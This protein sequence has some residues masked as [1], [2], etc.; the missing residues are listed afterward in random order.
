MILQY[1]FV[2]LLL[3]GAIAFALAPI[4]V[5][6]LVAPRKRAGNKADTFECGLLPTDETWVR[7]RVQ[8][9]VYALLFVVFDVETVFLYPWA[10]SYWGLS[11]DGLGIVV[12]IEM[13]IFLGVLAAALIYAWVAGDLQWF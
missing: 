11:Q 3:L 10:A 1:G 9:F 2:G 6:A 8:Y 13:A 12:L 5:A 7:F 4:G